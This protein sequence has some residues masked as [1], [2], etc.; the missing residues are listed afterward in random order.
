V[1]VPAHAVSPAWQ[2]TAHAPPE[3][4]FPA[5][6]AVPHLPQ[7]ALSV[8]MLVHVPPQLVSPI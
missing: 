6:Q 4:T 7:L 5:G 8:W 2:E 3:Q 1:Q